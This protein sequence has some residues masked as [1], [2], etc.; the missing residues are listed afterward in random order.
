MVA[1]R[2]GQIVLVPPDRVTQA[3]LLVR[4]Q[5]VILDGDLANLYEVETKALN[6]AVRRNLDRFPE[7]EVPIWRLKLEVTIWRLKMGRPALSALRF[8]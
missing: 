6:R 7:L 8:Y 2:S 4:G 1:K 3:I 5:K